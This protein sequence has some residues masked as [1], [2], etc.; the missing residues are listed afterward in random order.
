MAKNNLF[1]KTGREW[2]PVDLKDFLLPERHAHQAG[3]DVTGLSKEQII[4]LEQDILYPL[5][6]IGFL[7]KGRTATAH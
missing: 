5:D 2:P 3:W 4:M 7:I 6:I 1:E